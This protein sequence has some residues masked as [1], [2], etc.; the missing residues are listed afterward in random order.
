MT[1]ISERQRA[2]LYIN[3]K[4]KNIRNIY[5]YTKTQTLF[6]KQ[7]NLRYVFIHNNPKTLGYAIYHEIF[8]IGIFIYT[9]A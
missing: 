8:E 7:D 2:R 5:I 6:R 1:L 4:Q 3:K 9:K